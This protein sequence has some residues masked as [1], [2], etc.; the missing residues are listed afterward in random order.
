MIQRAIPTHQLRE[1]DLHTLVLL[2]D[3][4]VT[5]SATIANEVG[6][7]PGRQSMFAGRLRDP[8]GD[9]HQGAAHPVIMR[10]LPRNRFGTVSRPIEQT[11]QSQFL[12][13]ASTTNAGPR[14]WR[15]ELR[16]PPPGPI[17]A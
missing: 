12:A 5:T 17:G 15:P 6:L 16:H 8:I 2:P 9:Q 3:G 7:Q 10:I 13:K 1:V 11:T 4:L 14:C